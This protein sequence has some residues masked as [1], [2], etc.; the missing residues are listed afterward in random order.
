MTQRYRQDNVEVSIEPSAHGH[1]IMGVYTDDDTTE[2]A[3]FAQGQA[4]HIRQQA[5]RAGYPVP[6]HLHF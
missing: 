3:F 6:D 4:A 2:I 1:T 5:E